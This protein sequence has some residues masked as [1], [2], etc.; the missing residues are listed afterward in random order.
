MFTY[1]RINPIHKLSAKLCPS[2]CF[3]V[4]A[5]EII[6]ASKDLDEN[7]EILVVVEWVICQA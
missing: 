7:D 4:V 3:C 2:K 1:F 6:Y 5:Y